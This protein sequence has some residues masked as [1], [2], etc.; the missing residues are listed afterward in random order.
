MEFPTFDVLTIVMLVALAAAA[1]MPFSIS[2]AAHQ[3]LVCAAEALQLPPGSVSWVSHDGWLPPLQPR[4]CVTAVDASQPVVHR[5]KY[6]GGRPRGINA[7]AAMACLVTTI[8]V[9]HAHAYYR[10]SESLDCNYHACANRECNSSSSYCNN[11][12]WDYGCVSTL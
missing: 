9:G 8:F 11:G 1:L 5:R 6:T 3:R 10:C 2:F 4:R 12:V 7:A